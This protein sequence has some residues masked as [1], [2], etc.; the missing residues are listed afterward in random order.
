MHCI[1]EMNIYNG[2]AVQQHERTPNCV[3]GFESCV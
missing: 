1:D 2:Y 3:E